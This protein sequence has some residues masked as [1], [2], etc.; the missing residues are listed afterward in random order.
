MTRISKHKFAAITGGLLAIAFTSGAP[1]QQG[2]AERYARTLAEADITARY[3]VQIEQQ[4]R[5]QQAEIATLEQEIA[6]LDAT[7]LDVQPL[8]QRM[9]AELEQFV[10]A[11]VPF[12]QDERTQRIERLRE[13]MARVDAS[14]SEKFRRLVEAYQIEMEYGRTM[15]A[16][17]GTLSD[18]RE[19]EFVRLGRVSLL[20]R[21]VDGA[22]S[23]YWDNQQRTWVPDEDSASAIEEA[24]AI[25]KEEKAAD[26]ITVPVPAA[27]GERS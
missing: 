22:E 19:A 15:T 10:G 5:S 11:D 16:Y 25:A 12:F 8:L 18:G 27:Q 24:L 1:A 2:G 7:A 14:A 17:K 4:L 23:G 21:T 20:Y 6:A 13:L 3:N 26:L 9:F